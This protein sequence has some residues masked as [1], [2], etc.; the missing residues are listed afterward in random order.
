MNK[1][2]SWWLLIVS[3]LF[4]VSLVVSNLIAG[5]L[6][7]A[8]FGIV[9]PA[10]VWLFPIVYLIGDV[11]PE[12]YGLSVARRVIWLGFGLNALAILFFFI[13]LRLPYPGFWKGQSSF[14]FV[15]GFTPRLLIASFVG[16]LVGTNVNAW[17]LVRVKRLTRS[18][19]LWT[20]TIS[21]T[22]CGEAVDSALFISIAFLGVVP[23][24]VV[25]SMIL[26]QA[27]FKIAY[28]VLATP[29]TYWVVAQLKKREGLVDTRE[30]LTVPRESLD[31]ALASAVGGQSQ[32][33]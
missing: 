33:S 26:W 20:R 9:L 31:Q 17:V 3:A 2:I 1:G 5:K 6:W 13:T 14:Q 8:P 27:T 4:C 23:S 19:W 22:I 16:Y 18:R 24:N 12:V 15:L 30:G 29:L 7:A 10:G 28:E 11:I 25:R 32:A 21:S